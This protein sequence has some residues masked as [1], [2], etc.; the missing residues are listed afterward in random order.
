MNI[1]Q[2]TK[3]YKL[4]SILN[5]ISDASFAFK[6]LYRQY[7][8]GSVETEKQA[9]EIIEAYSAIIKQ[10]ISAINTEYE[11]NPST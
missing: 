7:P 5:Q 4:R 1:K 9:D 8:L 2:R 11:T 6:T 3:I 10:V